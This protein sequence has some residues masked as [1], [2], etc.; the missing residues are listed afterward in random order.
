[1]PTFDAVVVDDGGG[2]GAAE[3]FTAAARVML[4]R[5]HGE[6]GLAHA[7]REILH[8][9]VEVVVAHARRSGADEVQ[10]GDHLPALEEGAGHG[11]ILRVSAEEHEWRF[12]RPRRHDGEKASRAAHGLARAALEIVHVVV[13]EHGQRLVRRASP[14]HDATPASA[15]GYEER[16]RVE[17]GIIHRARGE[18][19]ECAAGES[20]KSSVRGGFSRENSGV[21]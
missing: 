1:M 6:I 5:S 13:V 20:Q 18:K 10:S 14:R 4:A 19:R 15:R 21:C 2:D 17:D 8:A 12:R 7:R 11:R 16:G 3:V 9:E